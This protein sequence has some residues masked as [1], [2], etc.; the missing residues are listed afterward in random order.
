VED[1]DDVLG[2][3]KNDGTYGYLPLIKNRL[4]TVAI[5]VINANGLVSQV[6]Y[7][8]IEPID[9]TVSGSLTITD[10]NK[11]VKEGKLTFTPAQN[12]PMDA[13]ESIYVYEYPTEKL[14]GDIINN[15]DYDDNSYSLALTEPGYHK[16]SVYAVD[17]YGNYS[18]LGEKVWTYT[19]AGKPVLVS[20]E[21]TNDA[22][23][24]FKA[25]YHFTETSWAYGMDQT[26][27]LYF[28][29]PYM[30]RLGDDR[31]P[32][33]A[34]FTL[35]LHASGGYAG[36]NVEYEADKPNKYGIYK[37]ETTRNMN[38]NQNIYITVYGVIKYDSSLAVD[39]NVSHTIYATLIDPFGYES[40]PGTGLDIEVTNTKPKYV[41]GY[42][43]KE[44]TYGYSTIYRFVA[45]FNTPVMLD[46]SLGTNDP[47]SYCEIK[48]GELPIFNDGYH[49][50]SFYDIF[51]T[52]WTQ[53]I[54]VKDQF[55]EHGILIY[56]SET[57]YTSESVEVTIKPVDQDNTYCMVYDTA[58]NNIGDSWAPFT[59]DNNMTLVVMIKNYNSDLYAQESIYITNILKGAPQAELHWYYNEFK[60]DSVPEGVS[61]TTQP[62]TVWYTSDRIVTPTGG[63]TS[64]YT[65][66]PGATENSYTFEFVDLA[67][68]TGHITATLPISITGSL[69]PDEKAP[70]YEI[71][72]YARK[73]GKDEFRAD[74]TSTSLEDAIVAAGYVQGYNFDIA[75][76]EDSPYKIV[77][78]SGKDA[79]ISGV[80]YNSSS[81]Q[82]DGVTQNK[83]RITVTKAA[84]FTVVIVDKFNNKS[85]FTIE[86]GDY[87]DNTPPEATV[88]KNYDKFVAMDAYVTLS[89]ESDNGTDTQNVKLLSPVGMELMNDGRYYY[90]FTD[91]G[92]FMVTFMDMA[93]NMGSASI[94]VDS[95]DNNAPSASVKWSPC[96]EY[97]DGYMDESSP[98]T[99]L[100]N[101]NV[102]A[103]VNY[104]KPVV[105]TAFYSFNDG[106]TWTQVTE[107]TASNESFTL[108]TSPDT[109]VVT[110]Y[111]GG[112]IVRLDANALNEKTTS[113][114]LKLDNVIIKDIPNISRNVVYN[115]REGYE[116]GAPVSAT[117]TFTP[118]SIDVFCS[119]NP[120]TGSVIKVEDSIS[121]TVFRKG[122]YTY[123]FTDIVGNQC[124]LTVD[125]GRDMDRTAPEIT[126]DTGD[127]S[128]T[129]G[130]VTITVSVNEDVMMTVTGAGNTPIFSG[131]VS[132]GDK[133]VNIPTNGSYE[134]TAVDG[135]GNKTTSIFTVGNID[136]TAPVIAF[137]PITINIRQDSREDDLQAILGEGVIVTDN[138]SESKNINVSWDIKHVKLNKT[139]VYN[140]V[141]TAVD[142]AGNSA[143]ATRFVRVYSKDELD[144]LLNGMK[145]FNDGTITVNSKNIKITV[146]NPLG[147]EPYTIYL[148]KN[149]RYEGQMKYDYTIIRP[150]ANG[151]FS[152]PSDNCYY[153][154]YIVTQSR[155]TYI[156]RIYVAREAEVK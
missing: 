58:S 109:A 115:Y 35:T 41:S 10:T 7:I 26:L 44:S 63:T 155:Q 25:T 36:T 30:D 97:E 2:A 91:S 12:Q 13:V 34:G 16:Y 113:T 126:I 15:Y 61:E 116:S 124:T 100:T 5:Q 71:F 53:E 56:L 133:Q 38:D 80:T 123:H 104:D 131:N 130:N 95:L 112:L 66:Y 122:E 49:T 37:V 50:I 43:E 99:K 47:S 55:N 145:T 114:E 139:G 60:S 31:D 149:I 45:E 136:K 102:M 88:E 142:E 106:E 17:S 19:D 42:L 62:V 24:Y 150:D 141:Y 86:V 140:V 32:A 67:G 79:N 96:Y 51:G 4:N 57:G 101:S 119:E 92:T 1:A 39:E 87:L 78:L 46:V 148:R 18:L 125:I 20:S 3:Y 108:K 52:K 75:V 154:L 83:N 82:L 23:G 29:D 77:I 129:G 72:I 76:T 14:V 90:R 65:F 74:T 22:N 54:E 28:D 147:A 120:K 128:V 107:S 59:V 127:G 11:P 143:E 151:S 48:N 8:Y 121:F 89:D 93:G 6:K 9:A 103:T 111:R 153:T 94:T 69:Q 110:F 117:I 152:V 40:D 27:R 146:N 144:V 132:K 135:S 134:V 105:I 33:N 81:A 118:E 68:N 73:N 98:P 85:S 64:S 156:T 21:I 138:K 70:E 137:D 84:P